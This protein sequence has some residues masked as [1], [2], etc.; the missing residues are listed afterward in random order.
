MLLG[1][2]RGGG[3]VKEST[4]IIQ[5][6]EINKGYKCGTYKSKVFML[7][8]FFFSPLNWYSLL[9]T[10]P[11]SSPILDWSILN[12]PALVCVCV[13]FHLSELFLISPTDF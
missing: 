13:C 4:L 7:F 8:F 11:P 5:I 9:I 12:I 3:E 1:T 2:E 10:L 6:H